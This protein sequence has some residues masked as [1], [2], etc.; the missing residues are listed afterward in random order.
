MRALEG[1]VALVT[2]ASRGIG[3]AIAERFAAEGARVAVSARTE[4]AHPRLPG[5][6]RETVERIRGRGGEARAFRCDLT[7]PTDR[8]R[9]VEAVAAELGPVEVL[10]NNAA[11]SFYRPFLDWTERRVRV[12][13]EV[14][15]LAPFDLAQRVVPAMR[16]RGEGF[17]LNISS[18]TARHPQG[19]P[20]DDFA[21]HGGDLLYGTTKAAL[22][23]MSTGLAAELDEDGIVVNALSPV[24]AV[25]TP[26]VEALGIVPE[27]WL[28]EAEPV[29]WM[30]E[31]ALALC[32][33]GAPSGRVAL[34]GSLLEELGRR[35]HSLDGARPL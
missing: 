4:E 10:V 1:R 12:A 13:F 24:A 21:R 8:A 19:P 11:A 23:R 22:D 18:A 33:P 30:A 32:T 20:W 25:R 17:V 27:A 31:A 35:P 14:N 34:S 28:K 29:E 16:A 2:G 9:L 6:L 7:E 15:V 26:G 5:S 3:A